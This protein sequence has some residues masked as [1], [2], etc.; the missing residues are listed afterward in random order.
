MFIFSFRILGSLLALSLLVI[1]TFFV[2]AEDCLGDTGRAF[3]ED[4][5]SHLADGS[6]FIFMTPIGF[7]PSF[8]MLLDKADYF[9]WSTLRVLED[10]I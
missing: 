10:G 4:R 9:S 2:T 7:L 3:K 5:I 6:L 1:E 8:D